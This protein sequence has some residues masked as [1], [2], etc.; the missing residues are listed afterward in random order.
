MRAIESRGSLA[1]RPG[2]LAGLTEARRQH[3]GQFF[4]PDELAAFL[5]RLAEP[6]FAKARRDDKTGR[7]AILDNSVGS[8]RLLQFA[9]PKEH[10]LAGVDVDE[11]A[12][13]KLIEV[14]QAAGFHSEFFAGGMEQIR[15]VGFNLGLIN[16]PFS[17][18]L[19]SPTLEAYDCTTHGKYGPNTSAMSHAYA[20]HQALDACQLVLAIVP[21]PY[22]TQAAKDEGLRERLRAII[23]PPPGCFREEGT[24]VS[25]SVLVFDS[26]KQVIDPLRLSVKSLS[27][28]VPDLGLTLTT[29]RHYNP[30]LRPIGIE[31]EKPSITLSVT[32]DN[33]V[34][35][36]HDGR[37]IKLLF[38]CG[39]TQAK[40]MNE[41]LEAPLTGN[42]M[43]GHRYPSRVHYMG[44]GVLDLEVHLAQDDPQA[45][46]DSFVKRI[47]AAGGKPKVYP[48]LLNYLKKRIRSDA[49]AR[50]PF[51][52][53]VYSPTGSALKKSSIT[54]KARK[55]HLADPTVWGSALIKQGTEAEFRQVTEKGTTLF[56]Y[57]IAGKSYRLGPDEVHQCFEVQDDAGAGWVVV[58][59]GKSAAFPAV[60]ANWRAMGKHLG[61]DAWLSWEYQFSDLVE[62]S[63]NPKGAVVAWDVGLGKARL[64]PALGLIRGARHTLIVVEPQLVPEMVREFILLGVPE[65]QWQVIH[66]V[67]D[68]KNLRALNII[69]YN[70]LRMPINPAHP[71]R[72]IARLL[73]RRCGVVVA[74]EGHLLRNPDTEQS[75]A[76]AMLSP[77]R[78]YVLT[79]TPAANYP[80]DVHA[81][82]CRAAGDGTA[83]QPYGFRGMYLDSAMRQSMYSAARG[84]DVFRDDFVSLEWCVNEFAED[85]RTGA[86]REVP[87][88]ANLQKY[89]AM[90]APHVLRRVHHEPEVAKYIT[91]PEP[92]RKVVT[93]DWDPAHLAY[94]LKV[95]EEFRGIYM[96]MAQAAKLNGKKMNLIALLA[97]IRA[98]QFACSYPQHH[99]KGI[100]NYSALTSKQRYALERL[101]QLAG[102]GKKTMLYADNPGVL[103]LLARHLRERGFNPVVFHG[104]IDID[105]R[106]QDLD[107]NFRFG[108]SPHCLASLGVTQTGLN[109]PQA[110]RVL[111]YNRAWTAKT[112]KQAGGRVLRPQQADDVMFEYLHLRGSIDEYQAQMVDFKYDSINA[113]L[114]WGTPEFEAEDFLHLDTILGRFCEDLE[115][116]YGCTGRELRQALVSA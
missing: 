16:P 107:E 60:A 86:K 35:V 15:P 101:S 102:E 65:D 108:L 109:I 25:V 104:K 95:A 41:V 82:I 44:Q 28:V 63:I 71:R 89:R 17:L 49:R 92:T 36:V 97:R 1:K 20:L 47:K 87:K 10:S 22:A 96:K 68:A 18:H 94:Y 100:G 34:R 62:L 116:M 72:T 79:A 85:N 66:S 7:F 24:E 42:G 3:L 53:T 78:F 13:K 83:N 106:T 40:V 46:F 105:T 114:D 21:R 51:R 11:E 38:A 69:A 73:R 80:R 4:T 8:G 6:A 37:R 32:G 88:I 90:L 112:E 27:E 26:A 45:S 99:I 103:E 54:G 91:I 77:K 61:L 110:S 98:V 115:N 84:V 33:T 111:F 9:D 59:E 57:T 30:R 75:R 93:L 39:L 113:G 14:T 81:L 48:G 74:D 12:I 64:A 70:R 52:H 58:H 19:E 43:E 2:S 76:L 67:K 5:W 23:D 55:T 31:D 50:T 29:N 56:E